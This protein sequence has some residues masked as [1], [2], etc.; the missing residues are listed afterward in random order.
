MADMTGRRLCLVSMPFA[1]LQHPSLALGLLAAQA[2]AIGVET[3]EKHFSF[4]FAETLGLDSYLLLS[5]ESRYQALL[6][7][8]IFSGCAQ[9]GL[10]DLDGMAYLTGV[11]ARDV[12]P[13]TW[14]ALMQDAIA[15]RLKAAAFV[16]RCADEIAATR[17]DVVGVTS[18]FQQVMSSIA[19]VGAVRA[20]LPDA[21]IVLG[22]ANCEG[23]LG[24]ALLSAHPQIDAV[25]LGEGDEAFP[26]FLAALE[27]RADPPRVAGMLVRGDG[28]GDQAAP[29]RLTVDLDALPIPDFAPFFDR[30][31]RT[32]GLGDRMVPAPTIETSRGCWWG[33]KHHCTFCGLNGGTMAYRSKSPE[34]AFAEFDVQADRHGPDF[35]VVDNILDHRY[36]D[37]L[38]PM[39]EA[40]ER[41]FLMHYEVK[42]NLSPQ[43]IAGLARAGV[44]KIQPGIETLDSGILRRM[45][46][47]VS[48]LQNVQTL[49]LCAEAGIF[50]DWGFIH[51][52]PGEDPEAYRRIAAL[53]PSL[54][55]LQPPAQIGPVR[56]DRFSPYFETPEAFGIALTPAEPYFHIFDLPPEEV[57]RFAYHFDIVDDAPIPAAERAAPAVAAMRRWQ[58]AAAGASL[59]FEDDGTGVLDGRAGGAPIRH[60]LNEAE[61]LILAECAS[62]RAADAVEARVAA[63]H[64]GEAHE[65]AMDRLVRLGL[66]LRE[67]KGV[68][69]LV[70][71]AP[72]HAAAPS[73]EAIRADPLAAFAARRPRDFAPEAGAAAGR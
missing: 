56:A 33:A 42:A 64:G 3:V 70:L 55:H 11:L 48:A 13:M 66:A 59:R 51:G 63:E 7:E 17:P 69:S 40:D 23:P 34:R 28:A 10:R 19:L 44:R 43:A 61:R 24:R 9:P 65:P 20:R 37:T 2:R 25:C 31:A 30:F 71:R 45:R 52:F 4:D 47:G 35:V 6:G 57:A 29:P 67:G 39:L 21:C 41:P 18:S 12:E 54:V 22:G 16:D 60:A 46:K 58:E 53:V 5:D 1:S 62:I 36:F 15:A 49:K 14:L 50:V 26:E 68:L 32:P 8:W 27:S 72:G 38:L 73:W